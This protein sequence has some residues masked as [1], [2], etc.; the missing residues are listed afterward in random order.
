M[1]SSGRCP[2]FLS[3]L[4]LVSSPCRLA[5][6]TLFI[7]VVVVVASLMSFLIPFCSV[8]CL[9]AFHLLIRFAVFRPYSF[10]VDLLQ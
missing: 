4:S 2:G 8:F 6:R 7:V 5:S 9:Q 1:V 3:M 10:L